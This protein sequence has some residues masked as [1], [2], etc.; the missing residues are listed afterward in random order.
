MKKYE[1]V[2]RGEGLVWVRRVSAELDEAQA[3]CIGI[4]QNRKKFSICE[5][6]F[7]NNLINCNVFICDKQNMCL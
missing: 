3:G 7:I 2:H 6:N 4:K 5:M 1:E